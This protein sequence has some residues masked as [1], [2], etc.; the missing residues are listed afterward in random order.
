MKPLPYG[1]TTGL[2]LIGMPVWALDRNSENIPEVPK[3]FRLF[4]E[5]RSRR[6]AAKC[7]SPETDGGPESK[8]ADDLTI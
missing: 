4:R 8:P 2:S 3:A 7:P 6:R 5:S 1:S